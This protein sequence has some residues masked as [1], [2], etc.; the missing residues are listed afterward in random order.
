[1]TCIV[2]WTEKGNVWIGGDSAGVAGYSLRSRAD[3][4]VFKKGEFVFGFTSSFR[5]GQLIRYQLVIPKPEEGQNEDDYLHVKFLDSVIEC[6]K[7]NR[8]ATLKD[9]EITGGTFL[10][11]YRGKLY[12]VENDFQI[13]KTRYCFDAVGC[14]A[15]IAL[16]CLY[17]LS[18]Q[19]LTPRKRV[20]KA[21]KAAQEFSAGVREPFHIEYIE[22]SQ[23]D[24]I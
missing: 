11:G 14:G 24:Q 20:E 1:M 12:Q 7:D 2:G 10:F 8:Y 4:K 18:H 17:G 22:Q 13:A 23:N 16:G 15:E 6:F 19:T 9:G 3:E 5:M 21:L